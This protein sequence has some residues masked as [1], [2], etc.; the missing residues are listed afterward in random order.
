M[1]FSLLGPASSSAMSAIAALLCLLVFTAL[2][3]AA[4]DAAPLASVRSGSA[5]ITTQLPRT[6]RPTHYDLALASDAAAGCFAAQVVIDVTIVSATDVITLNAADLT[7]QRAV[8]KTRA[9]GKP[10]TGV[11][12]LDAANLKASFRSARA[13]APGKYRLALHYT[14]VIGTQAVGLFSLDYDTSADCKR[15]L[16]TQFENSDARRMIPS[17]D[18]PAYKA[19]FAVRAIVPASEMAVSTMSVAGSR[20]L[21]DGRNLVTFQ[22]T[23]IMSTYLLVFGLGEW[24]AAMGKP[25]MCTCY[26]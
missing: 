20:K 1:H 13:V 8:L 16:Y 15:A 9:G 14:G 7:F 22:P 21:P 4:A 25:I 18:E 24:W 23:P 26:S 12:S 10:M 11:A 17:W 3:A 2:P 5:P 19:G 6:V